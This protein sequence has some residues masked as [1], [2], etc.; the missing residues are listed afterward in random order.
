V[1]VGLSTVAADST[2]AVVAASTEVVVDTAVVDEV[3]AV[4]NYSTAISFRFNRNGWQKLP[5]VSVF[6][7]LQSS[8]IPTMAN[9]LGILWR[10]CLV[11]TLQ[12]LLLL[13]VFL[14]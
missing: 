6:Y 4:G 14:H 1:A 7:P 2:E 3:A 5:A 13:C 12:T 11:S 8:L 9:L 10:R